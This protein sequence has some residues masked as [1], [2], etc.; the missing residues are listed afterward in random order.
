M[1]LE[2]VRILKQGERREWV[3]GCC[4]GSRFSWHEISVR[5]WI[6]DIVNMVDDRLTGRLGNHVLRSEYSHAVTTMLRYDRRV[7]EKMTC[8]VGL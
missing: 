8:V 6:F 2:S 5:Y 7:G 4:E 1:W 3:G